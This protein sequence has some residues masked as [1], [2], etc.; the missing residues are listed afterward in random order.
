MKFKA[1]N[2]SVKKLMNGNTELSVEIDDKQNKIIGQIYAKKQLLNSDLDVDIDKY[3][4]LRSGGHNRLFWDMCGYLADHIN[5]STITAKSIYQDLIRDHGVSTIYPVEDEL[6]EL[7]IKDW[8]NRGDGWLT[9]TQR[10][11]KIDE[12]RT[13]V[14]FW[15][16]SSIYDSKK[17]WKLVEA[18]KQMCRDNDLDISHYDQKI[19]ASMKSLE[20]Q[21][22]AYEKRQKEKQNGKEK[23]D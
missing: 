4:K 1:N 17:F 16:G 10:K 15:F 12:K 13:V 23:N 6:L 7:V 19:E 3:R 21:E 2:L 5:D 22:K 14:K 20:E 8:E 9:Q 11:S 18:L